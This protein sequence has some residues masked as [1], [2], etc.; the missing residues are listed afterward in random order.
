M[1]QLEIERKWIVDSAKLVEATQAGEVRVSNEQYNLFQGYIESINPQII[2]RYRVNETLK[3][4]Y[5]TMKVHIQAG[6][7]QEIEFEIPY[8]DGKAAITHCDRILYKNR[9]IIYFHDQKFEVDYFTIG[10][11]EKSLIIAELELSSLDQNVIIPDWCIEEVTDK[12]EY[13]NFFLAKS[14]KR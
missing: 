6:K 9:K 2:V 8:P 12:R 11:E 4:A 5:H 7:S 10:E 14:V 13:H 3:R 1:N